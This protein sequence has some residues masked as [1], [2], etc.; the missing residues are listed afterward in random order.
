MRWKRHS[1][2]V[3]E[4]ASGRIWSSQAVSEW[5]AHTGRTVHEE[6]PDKHHRPIVKGPDGEAEVEV[7]MPV[8]L[9]PSSVSR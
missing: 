3:A 7:F 9:Y 8:T 2:P 5:A 6:G 4:L 1:E